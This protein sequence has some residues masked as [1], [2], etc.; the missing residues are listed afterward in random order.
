MPSD[1]G[2][3][4]IIEIP[5]GSRN[6]YEMDQGTGRIRLD[7][8]L[9]T[10]TQYPCDYG[11]VPGSLAEDGDPLDAMV[12]ADEP[13]F[14]GVLVR[15]RTVGVFWMRDECGADAKLLTV[16]AGDGRFDGIGELADT[17]R[18]LCDEIEHF[19]GV[20]KDLE[21]GKTGDARGWQDRA[22]AERVLARARAAGPGWFGRIPGVWPT[23]SGQDEIRPP[24][25]GARGHP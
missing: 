21:P 20:Y 22:A 25:A 7:R 23:A 24:G 10:A 18:H 12:L 16:P 15:V 1:R 3:D 11:F 5:R 17:P 8:M 13:I 14:P 19:F 6:K 9:F 2:F 4:V